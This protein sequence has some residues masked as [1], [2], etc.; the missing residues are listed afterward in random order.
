MPEALDKLKALTGDIVLDNAGLCSSQLQKVIMEVSFVF[1]CAANVRFED[2][3]RYF[4]Y[5]KIAC[6][7]LK[8]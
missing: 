5:L 8:L 3:A 4:S 1:H 6:Y 7:H 2:D